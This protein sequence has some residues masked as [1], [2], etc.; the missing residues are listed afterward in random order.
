MKE[1]ITKIYS[2]ALICIFLI[3]I[4]IP[5]FLNTFGIFKSGEISKSENRALA[6]K[7][8]LNF[9]KLDSYPQAF[10][11][12]YNDH[13]V[14]R[15]DFLATNNLIN[16]WMGK[17]PAPENVL[18][19][20]D[21]WLY[22]HVK[23]R[24]VYEGKFDISNDSIQMIVNELEYRTM[25]LN[26]RNIKFY[27][28]IPPIKAEI[29]P[30]YLPKYIKRS[31][32]KTITDKI[33]EAITANSKIN[34]ITCKN[35]L[36]Q[37][38]KSKQVYF[39][40]DNHWNDN[41]AY[42][43]YQKLINKISKDFPSIGFNPKIKYKSAIKQGGNLANMI[44]FDLLLSEKTNTII[45][46]SPKST[47]APKG[48]YKVIE[49]FAYPSE[50]EID[51]QTPDSLLPKAVII[52]DSFFGALIPLVSEHFKRS[53]Y[54]FDSWQYRFNLDIIE[55]E[56]PEVVILEIYEPHI[57]NILKNLSYKRK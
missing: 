17:S 36:L 19:G 5:L 27:V 14:Y 28:L 7:P 37:E 38:K 29:Y 21:N 32:H 15:E 41:G 54:I 20:I 23:E 44:G 40:Y 53:V 11:K 4:S 48:N 45:L 56:K 43:A 13:F 35:E 3:V 33:I 47:V 12:W 34:L 8:D 1:K 10:E 30:E 22:Y 9:K 46:E 6:K 18:L 25:E 39:K 16:F 42:I 2:I 26:R 24:N 49:D 51:K 50:Y 52:R 55:A 57:S 31:A